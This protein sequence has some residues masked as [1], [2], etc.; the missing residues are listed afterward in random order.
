[1]IMKWK[2]RPVVV[3]ILDIEDKNKVAEIAAAAAQTDGVIYHL[4]QPGQK[5]PDGTVTIPNSVG[6]KF[7]TE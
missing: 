3:L 4:W 6:H 1:M 5:V 7:R 2:S